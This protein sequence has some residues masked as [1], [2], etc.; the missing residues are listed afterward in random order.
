MPISNSVVIQK[1]VNKT[2]YLF[3]ESPEIRTGLAALRQRCG[4]IFIGGK[5]IPPKYG[6]E[7]AIISE[8]NARLI[9]TQK[10]NGPFRQHVCL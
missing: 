4:K 8:N 10:P 9:V 7:M 6:S 2:M 3:R 5:Y 1:Q